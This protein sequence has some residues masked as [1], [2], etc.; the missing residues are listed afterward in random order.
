MQDFQNIRVWQSAHEVTLRV[1]QQTSQFPDAERFGVTSQLRRACASIGANIA[2]GCVRATDADFR[3]YLYMAMGSA[4]EAQNFI[5]LSR[6]L[7][8]LSSADASAL[9]DELGRVKAMLA[10]FIERLSES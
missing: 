6:D 9:L 5:L 2:E 3:R 10:R 7:T 4:S 1:Y 8:Y